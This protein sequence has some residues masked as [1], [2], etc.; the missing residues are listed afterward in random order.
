[1]SF[2]TAYIG[3]GSN[4]TSRAGGPKATLA[5]AI[6]RLRTLGDVVAQSSFY[7]TE[8]VGYA[9]QPKFLNAA[10][11]LQTQLS[12]LELLHNLLAIE[13]EFGRDRSATPAKG[14]RTLD[15]DLLLVDDRILD[16]P[17][18]TVPH[19][20]IAQRRFVLAPLAEIAPSIVHP[21][22]GKSI[23]TLLRETPDEGENRVA[24]VNIRE[25]GGKADILK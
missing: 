24:A 21:V 19:P 15:L 6:T 5:A 13:R 14:P 23:A 2:N 25:P 1:M 22:A 12:P 10:I 8:P 7:E 11:A 9:E 3:L 17:Q 20:A 18:L 4:L 16:S